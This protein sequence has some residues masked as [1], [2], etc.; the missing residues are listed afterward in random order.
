MKHENWIWTGDWQLEDAAVP[1]LVYFRKTL[2][3]TNVPA[4]AWVQVSVD[5]RYKLYVN[6]TFVETG[7]AKG[8]RQVWYYDR[9]DLGP[10]LRSGE[11]VIGAAV[12][13]YPMNGTAGNHSLFRTET[14]GFYFVA[15]EPSRFLLNDSAGWKCHVDR[16]VEFYAEEEGFAPLI[17]HEIAST[18]PAAFRWQHAGFD[19]SGW[20]S[21][22]KRQD[23]HPA[24]SPGNLLPRPIPYMHRAPRRFRGVF[25]LPESII[26]AEEWNRFLLEDRPVILPAHSN[27]VLVLDAGEE[28]TGYLSMA[29]SGGRGAR[30]ELLESECYATSEPDG[31]L[32]KADRTDKARGVLSGY[33]DTFT[34]LGCGTPERQEVY[35]PYWFRTFRFI[36]MT[37][38][39][40]NEPLTL[41]RFVYE[42]TGY[43]LEVQTEVHTSDPTMAG[44]WD[45]SLRTLQR[46][47]HETYMDCPFYEQLQY[48]MD[49]RSEILYTYTVSADD[50]LARQAIDDFSRSQRADGLLNCSYPN[51]N[52]NVIPGFSIYFILMVHDHMMYFGDRELVRRYLPTIDRIL[53]FFRTHRRPEGLVDKLGDVN[54]EGACWSFIDWAEDW[55]PTTG[56]PKAGLRGPLTMESLLY[57]LGLQR[58]AEL[59]DWIGRHDTAKE[60]RAEAESVQRAIRSF[61]MDRAGML[62]DGPDSSDLSQ[63]CQVFGILT[64]TLGEEKGRANLLRSLDDPAVAKCTVAMGYYLFRALE[65]T[66]LYARTDRCWDIWRE[67]LRN[68]C[69]TCVEAD[70]DPR[71][72]CH[73]WGSLALYELP[74][75]IL[76]VR[77]GAPGYGKI[78][79]R[80]VP[81]YLTGASGQV[82]TPRGLIG[83]SW[84][85]RDGD[86]QTEIQCDPA[87]REDVILY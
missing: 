34:V 51:M 50:R 66:G 44:I 61:C 68:N 79:V 64:G 52:P 32:R 59:N 19:D 20:E 1:R 67:M 17:I 4:A 23:V 24:V 80:P 63:H 84:A 46:C 75:V 10:W 70:T 82:V 35:S 41:S 81:G 62:T 47:M 76:G 18:D 42:E 27:T 58:A 77:P 22:L 6:G 25:D 73:A 43:P 30:I 11:N 7:P 45:I 39:T 36:Q 28:M 69:T 9:I 57:V 87:L 21:A 3:L 2:F 33:R 71:S 13:R 49:T 31:S 48:A 85:L 26:P 60:Y 56:M 29:F 83:V 86:V 8:D 40:G 55:L 15:E 38:Q 78:L 12:L 53:D 16:H 54:L 72:E 5:T 74:S 14:P 37:V 65:Q